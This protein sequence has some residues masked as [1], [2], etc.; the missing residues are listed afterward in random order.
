MYVVAQLVGAIVG[1]AVLYSVT[2]LPGSG[3][4]QYLCTPV[5]A[6]ITPAPIVTAA[7][8]FGYELVI[9]FVLV[10]TYFASADIGRLETEG[11][12]TLGPLAIG[13]SVA[14]CHLWAVRTGPI[15]CSFHF[16]AVG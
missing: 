1:A 6:E 13:I 15:F 5:P 2:V 7:E 9:T 14:M 11:F 4:G 10:L 12:R 8:V 16:V 3:P